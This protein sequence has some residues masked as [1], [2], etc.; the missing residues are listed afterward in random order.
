MREFILAAAALGDESRV[1]I[2]LALSE[3]AE[4]EL[5]VCQLIELLALAPSTV[6]KHLSILKNAPGR[7]PQAG[8]VDVLPP[9][10]RR[11]AAICPRRSRLGENPRRTPAPGRRRSQTSFYHSAGE[12]PENYA[13]VNPAAQNPVPLHRQ[14]LPQPDRRRLGATLKPETIEAYSAG[15]EPHGMNGS[16]VAAMAEAGVDISRQRSKHVDELRTFPSTT[17]SPFATTPTK[18]ARCFP[19]KTRVVHV[20]FDDPPALAKA[21]ATEARPSTFTAAC[22]MKSGVRPTLPARSCMTRLLFVQETAMQESILP[23][24]VS[25]TAT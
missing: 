2:L 15:V 10:R 21:A 4:R 3:A 23:A 25:W 6:S 18:H 1:R 5:C 14:L 19:G 22:A 9:A 17:S 11:S 20:G 12:D 24:W 7:G 16:A 8:P 13:G